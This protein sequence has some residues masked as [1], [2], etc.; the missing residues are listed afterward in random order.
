MSIKYSMVA[1]C[2]GCSAEINRNDDAKITEIDSVRWDWKQDWKAKGIMQGL[3]NL[4]GK[5]KLFCAT[6][7]GK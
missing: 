4:Y 3:P 5:K 7:A 6:C 1:T 2:D